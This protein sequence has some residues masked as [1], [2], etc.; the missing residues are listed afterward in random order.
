[1]ENQE[2]VVEF[3]FEDNFVIR[4]VNEEENDYIITYGNLQATPYHFSKRE[5]AQ[6]CIKRKDLNLIATM[7]IAIAKATMELNNKNKEEEQK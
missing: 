5:D 6:E 1:M 2:Q 7:C 4:P 3:N